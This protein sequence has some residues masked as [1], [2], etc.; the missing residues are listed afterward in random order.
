MGGSVI[1]FWPLSQSLTVGIA[2]F[3]KICVAIFVFLTAY[4]LT[5]KYT[6]INNH[7][8]ISNVIK[9]TLNRLY[10]LEINFLIIFVLTLVYSFI[11]GIGHYTRIYGNGTKSL[12]R[13]LL[14]GLGLAEL[15]NSPTMNGT[16]WYMSLAIVII[17]LFPIIFD[18]TR[19]YGPLSIAF[20][21]GV[22]LALNL[23]YSHLTRYLPCIAMGILFADNNLICRLDNYL[24]RDSALV[25]T[26][27]FSLMLLIL[28]F[29]G[30]SCKKFFGYKLIPF[31][32]MVISTGIIVW[33]Y[34]YLKDIYIWKILRFLGKHSLNMFLTHTLIRHYWY[35]DFI[36]SF[37]YAWIDL[38][39]L[40]IITICISA[41]IEKIKDITGYSKLLMFKF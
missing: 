41:L 12:Y 29:I 3:F 24:H 38:L 2:S 11:M 40:F 33:A 18:F 7:E 26:I 28:I 10:K 17:V 15:F 13:C 19:K 34:T 8:T 36:Y 23:P 22:P 37:Y 4:G 16:W 31:F 20:L 39:I 27:I 14:D 5:I 6:K 35:H 9:F 30:T 32:D 21:L 25:K 1:D